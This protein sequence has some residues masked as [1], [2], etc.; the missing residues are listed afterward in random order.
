MVKPAKQVIPW[1]E[2]SS[3][4]YNPSHKVMVKLQDHFEEQWQK[5]MHAKDIKYLQIDAPA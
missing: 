3:S 5:T 2:K 1:Q 4:N